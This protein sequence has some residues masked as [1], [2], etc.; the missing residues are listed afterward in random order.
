MANSIIHSIIYL[1]AKAGHTGGNE[2]TKR[3]QDI[4][5]AGEP[6]TL[7]TEENILLKNM[8]NKSKLYTA[9]ALCTPMVFFYTYIC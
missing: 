4:K 9:I 2:H 3:I 5:I 1:Y 8:G 7:E 6:S